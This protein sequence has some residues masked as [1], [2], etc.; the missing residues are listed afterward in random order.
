MMIQDLEGSPRSDVVSRP[1]FDE[2][3]ENLSLSIPENQLF[4]SI[5]NNFWKIESSS[6][7]E[8][9]YAGSRKLFDP[10]Y[11]G[12]LLDHHRYAIKGGSVTDNAPF[13]TFHGPTNYTTEHQRL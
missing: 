3:C 10:S 1:V 8:E 4:E 2:Y 11:K 5:A 9:Q 7:I 6:R 13:G 12:Y